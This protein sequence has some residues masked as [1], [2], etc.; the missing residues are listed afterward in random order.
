MAGSGY[1]PLLLADSRMDSNGRKVTLSEELVELSST[2]GAPDEDD[3]LVELEVIEE[4]VELAVLLLLL[5]LNIV[6]L[7]TVES[8]LSVLIH[9]VLRGVLHKLAADGLD[10]LGQGGREHHHLLLLGSGAE[11]VLDIGTH[12]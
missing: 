12:V 10:L 9:I 5:E 2:D 8:E 3:D 11:H 1:I 7:E 6:L 4:L